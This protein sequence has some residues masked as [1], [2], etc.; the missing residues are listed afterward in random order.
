LIE[1]DFGGRIGSGYGA[2]GGQETNGGQTEHTV[3]PRARSWSTRISCLSYKWVE[4]NGGAIAC[5]GLRAPGAAKCVRL[6]EYCPLLGIRQN[7]K[8]H[9]EPINVYMGNPPVGWAHE[10]LSTS[11]PG[12]KYSAPSNPYNLN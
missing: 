2:A 4:V 9:L 5:N 12:E 6:R 8:E 1:S 10:I 3:L 7:R 11:H